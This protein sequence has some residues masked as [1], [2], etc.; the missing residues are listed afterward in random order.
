MDL[1]GLS[2]APQKGKWHSM[3]EPGSEYFN[4]R[5]WA[6]MEIPVHRA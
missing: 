2:R 6:E 1:A 5:V 4:T 3:E